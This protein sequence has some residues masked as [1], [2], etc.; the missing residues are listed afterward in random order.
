[1]AQQSAKLTATTEHVAAGEHGRSFPPFDPQH[2]ASQLFWLAIIFAALYLLMSR[3]AL[4]RIGAILEQRG[5][6]IADDLQE[7][8]RLKEQSDAAIA[9]HE[10]ALNE[11]RARAQALAN[12]VRAKAAAQEQ[13]RRKEVDAGLNRRIAEAEKTIAATR[14]AAMGNVRGIASEAAAAIVERL[15]GS[16]PPA[17]EVAEAVGATVKQ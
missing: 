17:Q 7:A 10:K 11:A 14:T 8:S 3:L 13:A 4:P 16:V 2:F 1:M 6:R 15:I 12:T 5:R 9:A